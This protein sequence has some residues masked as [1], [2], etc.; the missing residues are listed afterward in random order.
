MSDRP[1]ALRTARLD[2]VPGTVAH[3]EDELADVTRLGARLRAQVPPGWPP[4][5]YDRGA[6]EFFLARTREDG[7]AAAGWYSWYIVWRGGEGAPDTLA[8]AIGC[9]GPP[10]EG[11]AE[12]GYSVVES[13]R[14]RGIAT[15]AIA[16]MAGR[17]LAMP[18]VTRVIAHTAEGN[19]H[20]QG[21]L[22]RAGFRDAGPGTQP[23]LRR[24]E[25]IAPERD[26]RG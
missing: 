22:R 5:E 8:G 18:G 15:E 16:A 1:G 13:F 21:A 9:L 12:I 25:R 17:L 6:I 4:G 19:A 3:Y 10:R 24:F 7:E 26:A 14:G 23:G 2:V 11:T 20:S